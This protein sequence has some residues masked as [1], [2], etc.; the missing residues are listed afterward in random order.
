MRRSLLSLALGLALSLGCGDASDGPG[1]SESSGSPSGGNDGPPGGGGSGAHG[2]DD[3]GD[4][5][6]LYGMNAGYYN[7]DLD[8]VELAELG[9]AA[10]AN[11]QRMKLFEPFLEQWGD[12]VRVEQSKRYL[13]MGMEDLVCFIIGATPEHSNAPPGADN[14]HYS[15][16]GLYEPIFTDAGDVNPQNH[17]AKFVER[18]VKTYRP[19]IHTWEVWNEPDQVGGNWQATQ[20]WTTD[21]PNPSDLVWW[22]D[23]IFAYIRMLRVTTQVVRKFDPEGR[24]ALGGIGYSSFLDAILRYTDEPTSGKVDADHPEKGGAWFDVVSYH[25]YPV[26]TPGSSDAGAKGI[27]AAHESYRAVLAKH[28]VTGKSFIVTESGAPRYKLGSYPGGV[29]YAHNYLLKAM[30]LAHDA[31]VRRIDWF[32]LGDSADAGSSDESFRF[33]GLYENLVPVTNPANAVITENGTAYATIGGLLKGSLADREATKELGLPAGTNGVALQTAD[34]ERA[35]VVWAEAADENG[36]GDV[37]LP[38][39][40]DGKLYRWDHAKTKASETVAAPGGEASVHV[41]SSPVIV[42][43]PR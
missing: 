35:Y 7:P 32:I 31:G 1:G 2:G 34:G 23:T 9:M 8:D 37:T 12:G 29:E 43:G 17:W 38:L 18:L 39:G 20:A 27:V 13:E 26:F 6:F 30:A 11:S 14:E 21:P 25:Y 40:G 33:M 28:G 10:G 4:G 15:P 24:V 19:Y 3:G 42:I 22:N 36:S 16:K 41:T 5:P